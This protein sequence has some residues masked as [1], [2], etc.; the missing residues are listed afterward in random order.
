MRV[1]EAEDRISRIYNL[2]EGKHANTNKIKAIQELRNPTSIKELQCFLGMIN[3]YR[4][5][6]LSHSVCD[7]KI[8]LLYTLKWLMNLKDAQGRLARWALKLQESNFE[9]KHIHKLLGHLG[10]EKVLHYMKDKF[11][12]GIFSE[13]LLANL[14]SNLWNNL[15]IIFPNY[16]YWKL[17]LLLLQ[18]LDLSSHHYLKVS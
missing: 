2:Q 3:Y 15:D 5:R 6:V 18:T 14:T 12:W 8:P 11:Y 7:Q 10:F 4:K 17:T 13:K 1:R 9:I 16:F